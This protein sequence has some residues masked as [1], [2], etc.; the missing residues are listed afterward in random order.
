L[1]LKKGE[2]YRLRWFTPGGEVELCGHATLGTAFVITE[3]VEPGRK[4]VAFETL[5]GTL[6]VTREGGLLTMDFPTMKME[7]TEITDDVVRAIGV[8]PQEAYL[9]ADFLCVLKDEDEV[10][11]VQPDLEV[12]RSL[13]GSCFHVTARGE[14]YDCVTRSF[15][16]K[17][18]VVEDPVCGRAHCSVVPYWAEKLGRKEITAYQASRRGGVLYCRDEGERT[19]ISGHA[20]LFAQAEIFPEK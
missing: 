18:G 7:K 16:P 2:N 9:G 6:T 3:I 15:A 10:R 1:L 14:K 20:V 17:C 12:I 5:S 8:R 13:P 4:Q 19:V 11:A